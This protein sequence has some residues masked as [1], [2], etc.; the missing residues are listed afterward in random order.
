MEANEFHLH[1]PITISAGKSLFP[2]GSF[3]RGSSEGQAGKDRN[4]NTVTRWSLTPTGGCSENIVSFPPHLTCTILLDKT[5]PEQISAGPPNNQ[6][7][8][9]PRV[10]AG[11]APERIFWFWFE[12]GRVL[13]RR[14]DY[15][16]AEGRMKAVEKLTHPS[17]KFIK[18]LHSPLS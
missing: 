18:D 7:L 4:S 6:K 11:W 12:A 8:L 14:K 16:N 15:K 9:S 1:T 13:L 3:Y 10:S 17:D 2:S 5:R